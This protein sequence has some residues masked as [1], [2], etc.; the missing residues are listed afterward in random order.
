MSKLRVE[1][2]KFAAVGLL[3]LV[4]TFAIYSILL[5]ILNIGYLIAL[6]V[7]WVFGIVFSYTLNFV[8]VFTPEARLRYNERF[9]K[10][11]FSY[12]ISFVLNM[13]ILHYCVEKLN[14]DPLVVQAL[15]F[16]LLAISNFATSKFWSLRRKK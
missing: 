6:C 10:F 16:P 11:C 3:N 4:L 2:T 1:I 8:W 13:I 14:F 5:K 7:T 15:L 12:L 9:L